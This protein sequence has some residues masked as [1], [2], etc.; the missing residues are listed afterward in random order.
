V[1]DEPKKKPHAIGTAISEADLLLGYGPKISAAAVTLL[2][3]A[4]AV[5]LG[6]FL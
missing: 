1:T 6:W 3:A 5:W 2:L 4:E